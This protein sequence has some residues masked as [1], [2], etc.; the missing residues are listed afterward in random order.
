MSNGRG[1]LYG[2]YRDSCR[3]NEIRLRELN[4]KNEKKKQEFQEWKQ[5]YKNEKENIL[6][7]MKRNDMEWG[8]NNNNSSRY[9][10]LYLKLII[11]VVI[12]S[13]FGKIFF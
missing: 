6:Y 11:L 12:L 7:I 1:V 3:D 10:P 13:I 5:E 8:D 4:E 2:Y 9:M